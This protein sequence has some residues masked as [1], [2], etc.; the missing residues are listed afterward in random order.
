MTKWIKAKETIPFTEEDVKNYLDKTI[1]SW[2]K[3]KDDETA[4]YYIDA[5]QSVRTSLFGD[6]LSK[7]E[8]AYESLNE[9]SVEIANEM[10]DSNTTFPTD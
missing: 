2:R 4:E 6:T 1:E 5:F 9:E 10:L 3:K 8:S 7:E